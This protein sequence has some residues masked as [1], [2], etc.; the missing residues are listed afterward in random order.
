MT[1]P[2]RIRVGIASCVLVLGAL[3]TP[4]VGTAATADSSQK[5]VAHSAY[6][7]QLSVPKS[8]SVAYFQNCPLRNSGTLLIGTPTFLSNCA[9]IPADANIISM[10]PQASEATPSGHARHLV[11]HGVGVLS[12]S[13]SQIEW[14]VPSKHVVLMASGPQSSAILRTLAP[15]SSQAVPAPGILRGSIYLIALSRAPVT[16]AV[17]VT[18]LSTRSS[19]STTAVK[20]FDAQF[21]DILVPG[22]YLLTGHDGN[23][24]CPPV[25]V[26]VESGQTS[27][28]PEIDCQG[29]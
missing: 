27:D 3:T 11:V 2:G 23:A 1:S 14:F 6:G 4:L 13:T 18:R 5:R 10:Q 19:V 15:A 21:S 22:D 20:A 8:W 12:Y 7:L 29:E 9:M 24:P 26:T 28:A 25:R 17:S 16:G